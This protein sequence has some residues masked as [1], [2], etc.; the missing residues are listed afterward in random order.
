VTLVEGALQNV[1]GF[2]G[3]ASLLRVVT[4]E[5]LGWVGHGV[6]GASRVT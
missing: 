6:T 4:E 3:S 5:E 1:F 2:A